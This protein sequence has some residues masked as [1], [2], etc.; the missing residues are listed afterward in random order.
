LTE[1]VLTTDF[2]YDALAEL[3]KT[4]KWSATTTSKATT[5]TTAGRVSLLV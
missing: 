3:G 5:L 2:P 4:W 1:A